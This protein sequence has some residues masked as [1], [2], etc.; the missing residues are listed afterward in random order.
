M[1]N[2]LSKFLPQ[3]IGDLTS[4][5]I[6]FSSEDVVFF[7][8]KVIPKT[9]RMKFLDDYLK[10]TNRSILFTALEF[11]KWSS[12]I[13]IGFKSTAYLQETIID[14]LVFLSKQ[15]IFASVY[16]STKPA[17][18]LLRMLKC[19]E[20]MNEDQNANSQKESES[21]NNNDDELSLFSIDPTYS[22]QIQRAEQAKFDSSFSYDKYARHYSWENTIN[23]HRVPQTEMEKNL[24]MFNNVSIIEEPSPYQLIKFQNSKLLLN[25]PK[26][27]NLTLQEFSKHRSYFDI[28]D[29]S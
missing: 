23:E 6:S 17:A 13:V 10:S 19:L 9:F 25:L 3:F 1:Q 29:L 16:H 28:E 22:L 12:V 14:L 4:D 5:F 27:S 24:S 7:K 15:R 20:P 11:N 26:I 8:C 18:E 2:N 21:N